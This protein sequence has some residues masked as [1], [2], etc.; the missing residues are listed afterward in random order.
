[1]KQHC[2]SDVT[3]WYWLSSEFNVFFDPILNGQQYE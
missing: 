1:M 2:F 3:L